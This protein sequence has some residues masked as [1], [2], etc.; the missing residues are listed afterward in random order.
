VK[1]YRHPSIFDSR[2]ERRAI[3]D[4]GLGAGFPWM[5]LADSLGLL[6]ALTIVAARVDM[7]DP[8]QRMF[9]F[10]LGAISTLLWLLFSQ[11]KTLETIMKGR[12]TA[13]IGVPI[14]AALI[15]GVTQYLG[16][17]SVAVVEL[18]LFTASWTGVLVVSRLVY[19][20]Y[21]PVRTILVVGSPMFSHELD[22]VPGY[23]VVR[24]DEPP[25]DFIGYD[26][27][28]SDPTEAYDPAWLRWMSHANMY[29]IKV[30]PA[31][32][33][34][35]TLTGRVPFE[36]LDGRWAFDILNG[37][38]PYR[39]WKRAFDVTAVVLTA[40]FSLLVAGIV[41]LIV[42][43]DTGRPILFWQHRVG[44]G[45]RPFRMVKFRTMR[46]D[47]ETNGDAFATMDDSRVTTT[48]R[49]LRQY[50]LDEIPQLWN[51]LRGD[52][53]VIG[54]RPEQ[55]SFAKQFGGDI[56]LYDHR[57]SVAPGI[58]GWAQ[59]NDGYAASVDE[60]RSKLRHDFFYV[61]HCSLHLDILIVWRTIVTVM[62][63]FGSR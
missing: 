39:L 35:E 38:S 23:R 58:T 16:Y 20:L 46:T 30:L 42:L 60:T 49:F 56:P 44:Y 2:T 53:S 5:T 13:L 54:P 34:F 40:P 21:R 11:V 18:A 27:V 50:R 12:R 25:D 62:T 3:H 14:A 57:H 31:P 47:A 48:G 28:V 15:G 17:G 19:P 33:V 36:M 29:G 10:A 26:I 32:L 7:A 43:F 51:V 63:G 8:S 4:T 45:G 61:K 1:T 41:A 52:M 55:L 24:L 22:L 59:V 9:V 37:R 6:A